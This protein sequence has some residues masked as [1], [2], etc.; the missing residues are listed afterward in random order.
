MPRELMVDTTCGEMGHLYSN[1]RFLLR[2]NSPHHFIEVAESRAFGRLLFLNRELMHVEKFEF[3][4]HEPLVHVP[5]A[6][7]RQAESVLIVG[8]GDLFAAG[9]VLK[10]PS[11]RKVTVVDLDEEVVK[12]ITRFYP[13]AGPIRSD[14]RLRLIFQNGYE[15]LA[16]SKEVF[17]LVISDATDLLK[18]PRDVFG[19]MFKSLRPGGVCVDMI[20]RTVLYENGLETT[21][22]RLKKFDNLRYA[23]I[24]VPV[25][26]GSLHILALWGKTQRLRSH[27][28]K[29]I[30]VEQNSAAFS[31]KLK[32]FDPSHLSH[33]LYLPP[34]LGRRL[35]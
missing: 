32:Y 10:Y 18:E 24:S 21:S 22:I 2:K 29:S 34:F 19:L 27:K 33:F 6:F 3:L 13:H 1:L 28:P 30:N 16:S 17:D 23:L 5:M 20:Y 26:P 4:Y 11:V 25:F 15:F 7:L 12:A 8:G 35:S 14:P 9:E 31:R